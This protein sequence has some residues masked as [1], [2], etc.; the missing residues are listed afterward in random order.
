MNDKRQY[1][2]GPVSVD[3]AWLALVDGEWTRVPS[4]HGNASATAPRP[5]I[6]AG[7][8]S[9]D[10]AWFRNVGG[11]LERA[12]SPFPA[13]VAPARRIPDGYISVDGAHFRI[14]VGAEA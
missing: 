10:G 4:P 9:I 13:P 14:D 5:P 3:G 6:P 8:V 7:L 1:E 11:Q 12:A 2:Q